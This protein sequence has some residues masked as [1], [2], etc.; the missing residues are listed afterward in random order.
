MV[1]LQVD[2]L[3]TPNG[4]YGEMVWQWSPSEFAPVAESAYCGAGALHEMLLRTDDQGVLQLFPAVPIGN[5]TT[6]WEDVVFHSL[7]ATGNVTVSAVRNEGTVK[8]VAITSA[9]GGTM[10]L[11]CAVIACETYLRCMI[12]DEQVAQWM[13]Q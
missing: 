2:T 1:C 10:R 9:E 8:W 4:M 3:V 7:K 5:G 11:V 6:G 13:L 12:V